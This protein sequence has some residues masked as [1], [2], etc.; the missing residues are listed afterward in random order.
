M[1][2]PMK[3]ER[4]IGEVK[5][6]YG[7]FARFHEQFNRMPTTSECASAGLKRAKLREYK[8]RGFLVE[9]KRTA[10]NGQIFCTWAIPTW[11]FRARLIWF[12]VLLKRWAARVLKGLSKRAT[13]ATVGYR[14]TNGR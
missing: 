2:D 14:G 12:F 1:T 10:P 8:R 4:L 11:R 13:A 3:K 9:R 7:L 6:W 5:Y